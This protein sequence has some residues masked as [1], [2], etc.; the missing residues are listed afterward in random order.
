MKNTKFITSLTILLLLLAFKAGDQIELLNY[1]NARSDSK[2]SKFDKNI[3]AVL[4]KGTKGEI[5]EARK[6]PSGNFGLKIKIANGPKAG[7]AYWVYH[8]LKLPTIK[9]TD[10]KNQKLVSDEVSNA[11]NVELL[12][13]QI[14]IPDQDDKIIKNTVK[15]VNLMLSPKKIAELIP[16][17]TS[18]PCQNYE[19]NL[20]NVSE[21]QYK[22]TDLVKPYREIATSGLEV[23]SSSANSNGWETIA[24][25]EDKKIE[26]FEL[27]NIG[28][29]NIIKTSEYYIN[30]TMRFEFQDRASSDMKLLISDSPD[31]Y[32]SHTTYSVMLFFP[33]TILPSIN[34]IGEE[35]VVTL[36]NKEIV[37][38]NAKTKEVIGGVFTEGP[39]AQDPK[40]RN[41]AFAP[42]VKYTGSGVMIRADKSGDLPYGD[43]EIKGKPFPSISTATI[44]KKG[45]KDCKVPS[46]DL[47]YT[48]YSKKGNVFIKPE[49]ATD[50]GLDI[51]LKK[52]CG[53]SIF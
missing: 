16:P 48:D 5:L 10:D 24:N 39:I 15:N 30:R 34:K 43:I 18:I 42:N 37:R 46:K 51:F 7:E 26:G 53:F 17:A 52:K 36:P 45:F 25:A 1:L 6:M 29:N 8:N 9:L 28:P 22:E 38:Y 12:E 33:R 3:E 20:S 50:E 19:L 35:I 23:K 4:D 21:D 31:E 11:K 2:F 49:Y 14:A 41:K 44:S 13:K 47:W 27:S 32:T 40:N